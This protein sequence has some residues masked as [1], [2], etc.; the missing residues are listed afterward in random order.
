MGKRE[1]IDNIKRQK[2]RKTER[3]KKNKRQLKN[4]KNRVKMNLN[5]RKKTEGKKDSYSL[6]LVLYALYSMN[7]VKSF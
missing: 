5:R 7:G 4:T 2:D 6:E 3:I 1:V